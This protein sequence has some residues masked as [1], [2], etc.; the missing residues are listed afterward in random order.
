[1]QPKSTIHS[2]NKHIAS[3]YHVLGIVSG[4]KDKTMNKSDRNL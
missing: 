4:A 3:A 1:M 2:F